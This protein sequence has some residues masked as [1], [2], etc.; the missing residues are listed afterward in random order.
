MEQLDKDQ[1]YYITNRLLHGQNVLQANVNSPN[2]YLVTS[3]YQNK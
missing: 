2:M 1:H 3:R